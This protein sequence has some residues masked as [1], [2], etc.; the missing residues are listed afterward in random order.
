MS[1]TFTHSDRVIQDAATQPLES[2]SISQS[3]QE[4]KTGMISMRFASPIHNDHT[5]FP[6]ITQPRIS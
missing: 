3:T 6:I 1:I 5:G 4:T 2:I